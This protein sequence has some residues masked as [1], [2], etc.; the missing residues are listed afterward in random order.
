VAIE[1]D[2]TAERLARID[3]LV[4]EA[5]RTTAALV[6]KDRVRLRA[7]GE[8]DRHARAPGSAA[9]GEHG[10]A[11][12]RI[13]ELLKRLEEVTLDTHRITADLAPH[14]RAFRRQAVATGK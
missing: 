10:L 5:Q 7:A 8:T 12:G 6:P 14:R 9:A 1:Y 3:A 4:A 11:V 13:N 2:D